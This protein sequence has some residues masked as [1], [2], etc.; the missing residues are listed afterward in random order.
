VV[1]LLVSENG[2]P[3]QARALQGP[4]ALRGT[5]VS[6]ALGWRFEPS[7]RNGKPVKAR[8]RL[9]MPFRLAPTGPIQDFDFAQIHV[10]D[11]PEPP[12]YPAEAKAQ[13][14]QGT[15][16][17]EVVTGTDGRVDAAQAVEGPEALRSTAE[18]Y[19]RGWRFAPIKVD[20]KPVRA[21][22]KLT[23]PFRLR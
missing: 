3:L 14:I 15:V 5:A 16:V 18:D 11:Q 21:R 10:A 17:V 7:E 4:P 6:Y 9:S 22:F 19:A 23:M 13:R 20:G 2:I 1:E 12:A 8:F